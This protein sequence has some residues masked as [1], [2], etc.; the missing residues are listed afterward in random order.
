MI[1]KQQRQEFILDIIQNQPITSQEELLSELL[2][3]RVET[4]QTT[5]SRDIRALG[6][7][8]IKDI[9]NDLRY[10]QLQDQGE[11]PDLVVT[12]NA[13]DAAIIEY[14]VFVKRVQFMTIIRTTDSSGN[15]V[16]GIIDDANLPQ[17]IATLAG[18]DTI[19]VTSPD[20]VSA[21]AL[22]KRWSALI[23]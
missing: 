5:V 9:N 2:K 4:T 6:I 8:R 14:A 17:V 12:E 20:E 11:T 19:Y 16:A 1:S 10:Q 23:G 22:T 21:E 13:I 7:V 18:F 3:H 15:A